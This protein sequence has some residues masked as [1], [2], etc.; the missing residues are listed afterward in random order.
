MIY[1]LSPHSLPLGSL[2]GTLPAIS[3]WACSL[4]AVPNVLNSGFLWPLDS[5]YFKEVVCSMVHM[6]TF[7][8]TMHLILQFFECEYILFLK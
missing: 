5:W 7:I 3:Y 2:L 1:G 6:Y 8:Y 4:A